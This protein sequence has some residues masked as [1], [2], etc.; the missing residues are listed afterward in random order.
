MG[1]ETLRV[2]HR[3]QLMPASPGVATIELNGLSHSRGLHLPIPQIDAICILRGDWT[4]MDTMAQLLAGTVPKYRPE[5]ARGR[6][7]CVGFAG[8]GRTGHTHCFVVAPSVLDW[9][10]TSIHSAVPVSSQDGIHRRRNNSMSIPHFR[11]QLSADLAPT[12]TEIV[13]AGDPFAAQYDPQ[14]CMSLY[15]TIGRSSQLATARVR[16]NQNHLPGVAPQCVVAQPGVPDPRTGQQRLPAARQPA[17]I[18]V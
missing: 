13:C 12:G 4:R 18:D 6:V 1:D 11:T 15:C 7:G 10:T 9:T 8:A 2:S 3:R 5:I 17:V 16:P 14:H